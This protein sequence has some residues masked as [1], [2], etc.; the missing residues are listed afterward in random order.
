MVVGI[1]SAETSSLWWA[2][3]ALI[4][5]LSTERWLVITSTAL[6]LLCGT[7]FAVVTLVA[8]G[9]S[10]V[11]RSWARGTRD[12]VVAGVTVVG[13]TT[14]TV[15]TAWAWGQSFLTGGINRFVAQIAIWAKDW[16]RIRCETWAVEAK[17]AFVGSV[18]T[19]SLQRAEVPCNTG[20][21][22]SLLFIILIVASTARGW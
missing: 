19:H 15:L 17:W 16:L 5:S 6:S 18:V 20:I 13:E 2:G 1:S 12:A 7:R 9:T 14:K 10:R 22:F 4:L 21:T 8:R 11:V 3:D